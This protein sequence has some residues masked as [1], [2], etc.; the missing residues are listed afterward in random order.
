[1]IGVCVNLTLLTPGIF[2]QCQCF[3]FKSRHSLMS[4]PPKIRLPLF[5]QWQNF[6]S[7]CCSLSSQYNDS[8]YEREKIT[9]FE[10]HRTWQW[11]TSLAPLPSST[12]SQ[13]LE[14]VSILPIFLS[15]SKPVCNRTGKFREFLQELTKIL[16]KKPKFEFEYMSDVVFC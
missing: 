4:N 16:G 13:Y 6:E 12:M 2:N 1:M 8:F 15:N 14:A 3:F 5:W 9:T 11:S 7:T 10:H